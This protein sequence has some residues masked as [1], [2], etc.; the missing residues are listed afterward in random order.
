MNV[1]TSVENILGVKFIVKKIYRKI[2]LSQLKKD[3]DF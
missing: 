2:N 1:H 3:H